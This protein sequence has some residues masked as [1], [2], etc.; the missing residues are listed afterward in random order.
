MGIFNKLKKEIPKIQKNISLY[1]VNCNY[2]MFLNSIKKHFSNYEINCKGDIITINIDNNIVSI[3]TNKLSDSNYYE[4]QAHG[5]CNFFSNTYMNLDI[6]LKKDIL[7]QILSFNSIFGINF[8]DLEGSKEMENII[9]DKVFSIAKELNLYVLFTSTYE[10]YNKDGNLVISLE[11]KKCGITE[12]KPILK[13]NFDE[14]YAERII[15]RAISNAQI[16][17]Q[18]IACNDSLPCIESSNQVKLK[19]IDEIC[20][21]AIASFFVIQIACDI[22]NGRYKESLESFSKVLEKFNVLN[23]LNEKEKKILNGTY[24]RQD[25][26]DIDWEY[27]DCWTLLWTLGLIDDIS[28]ATNICDCNYTIN[29][30]MQISSYEDFKSRCNLRDINEILDMLDLYFRYH[31]ACVEKRIKPDTSIGNLNSSV[32]I[33]RRRALEWVISEKDSWYDISLDT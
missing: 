32:V 20:K 1:G 11:N 5:M 31:W 17:R 30:F 3:G 21:R 8:S 14:F 12:L 18:K 19:S 24:E 33:E 22:N 9:N 2:E 26:I 7:K 4:A 15:R 27:E 16:K 28:D 23:C 25:V 13:E 29:L 6:N 10:L